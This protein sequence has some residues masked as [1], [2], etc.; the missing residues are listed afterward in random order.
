MAFSRSG[1][2]AISD[3]AR[4]ASR[5]LRG[6]ATF[7]INAFSQPTI[8]LTLHTHAGLRTRIVERP[9]LSLPEKDLDELVSRL[10][11]VAGK[12]LPAG[13][14]SYGIFSGERERLSRAVI[15][16]IYEEAT[17]R[18]IA[19]NALAVMDVELDGEIQPVIHLGLVMIDPEAQGQ[20][21]SWV[22]YGLTTL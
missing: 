5:W 6:Y 8:D 10:R 15:T 19:F 20:G 12:T 11:I 1:I 13:A 18:P 21:L 4:F 9:G 22:L 16:L 7:W 17:G 14:L 2:S 3:Q